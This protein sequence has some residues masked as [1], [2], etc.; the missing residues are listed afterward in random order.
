MAPNIP[1]DK[2]VSVLLAEAFRI[3]Q[4][5]QDEEPAPTP[6]NT[7]LFTESQINSL[8]ARARIMNYELQS[9]FQ[10]PEAPHANLRFNRLTL[11]GTLSIYIEK[12]P[13]DTP[14][15]LL[16][17]FGVH[18]EN[19]NIPDIRILSHILEL[20]L[21][22][23]EWLE[24][25]ILGNDPV[26]LRK[27]K[28]EENSKMGREIRSLRALVDSYSQIKEELRQKHGIIM[29]P[30]RLPAHFDEFYGNDDDD[31]DY[32]ETDDEFQG[33]E[34][35]DENV[36]ECHASLGFPQ[37]Q[38]SYEPFFDQVSLE[39]SQ[40]QESSDFSLDQISLESSQ[41][42][43]SSE[44]SEDIFYDAESSSESS[45]EISDEKES[46]SESSNGSEKSE[47]I[48]VNQLNARKTRI[49]VLIKTQDTKVNQLGARKTRIPIKT[50]DVKVNQLKARKTRIP[51]L[52]KTQ[53]TKVNQLGARKSRVPI[54]TQDIKVNQFEARK[55]EIQIKT[56]DVDDKPLLEPIDNID[57]VEEANDELPPK[58]IEKT[59]IFEEAPGLLQQRE[60][61]ESNFKLFPHIM[62]L[63]IGIAIGVGFNFLLK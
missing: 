46:S 10:A 52:I 48:K 26:Q 53:D 14:E 62:T 21:K 36:D 33:E 23:T 39:S 49:P 6:I 11:A 16:T 55:N 18:A 54:K 61:A 30:I 12:F 24:I 25:N 8:R 5:A 45:Q 31:D 47:N 35:D 19:N 3:P 4:Y 43:E 50:Q 56:Q 20:L 28:R 42:Q 13:G 41:D 34:H 7:S 59:G 27:F 22:E 38:Q 17:T 44:F 1:S 29:A 40:D 37:D 9:P 60:R 58:S 57:T 63:A 32:D 15:D 2:P 51:V